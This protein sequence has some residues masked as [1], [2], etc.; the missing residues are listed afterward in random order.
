VKAIGSQ[1]G[2]CVVFAW[3]VNLVVEALSRH[4]V[5]SAVLFMWERPLVFAYNVLLIGLTFSF[6][7]LFKRKW[8]FL[9][10]MT[11][12][13][14]GLGITNS[15]LLAHRVTPFN[16]Q[17]M[18][19]LFDIITIVPRYFS[20]L[21]LAL[22]SLFIVAVLVGLVL[23]M[24][25]APVSKLPVDYG[26]S[27]ALS[28]LALGGFLFLT[29]L[30]IQ[31]NIV[32][33]TF[34]NLAMAY[35]DYGFPYAFGSSIFNTGMDEPDDYSDVAVGAIEG[36]LWDSPLEEAQFPNI[37]MVQLESF[38]DPTYLSGLTLSEDPIPNFRYL[39]DNFSSGFL[40][41]PVVGAGTVNTEF[42]V[43]TGMAIQFFGPGEIPY[44]TLLLDTA[45]ES[46]PHNLRE[47]GYSS[48]AFHN[49]TGT[50]Y[51]RHRVFSSL[52]F[53]TFT[54]SEFMNIED[55]SETGWASDQVMLDYLFAGMESTANRDFLFAI[56]VQSHGDYPSDYETVPTV[57]A[58]GWDDSERLRAFDYYLSTIQD[59]DRFIGELTKRLA[60]FPEEVVLVLYGDHLPT[61]YFQESE[62]ANRDIYQ[63]EFVVWS[64]FELPVQGRDLAA[65]ELGA[66]VLEKLGISQGIMTN[67]HQTYGGELND[68]EWFELL[69][70]DL[71][72]GEHYV[73]GGEPP[74]EP[75][76]LQMGI[77]PVSIEAVY[78]DS[79]G[80]LVVKGQNFTQASRVA[81]NGRQ[82][83]TLFV[84]PNRLKVEGLAFEAG[85][86]AT[87]R[88]VT[89][90]GKVLSET[91]GFEP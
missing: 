35:S 64:N 55:V 8:S 9:S 89:E 68:R 6:V 82:H 50:F 56:T 18:M 28:A 45:V 22:F 5:V 39:K 44:K 3:V 54:S 37:I 14:L 46:L 61:F 21:Q 66:F 72:F 29:Q 59:V 80:N 10:L 41:V 65:Y 15:L 57:Q 63:T 12:I 48:H 11:V 76:D 24:K 31:Q 67:F 88:Q 75:T 25:R 85:D 16:F 2:F 51:Q 43:L 34:G 77:L 7:I 53:D 40:R 23:L 81:V 79:A 83:H 73:Y 71:L 47:L 87:V 60:D 91:E 38:F 70:Y 84:S 13:W 1:W 20:W 30:A 19:V 52:G 26:L 62:L 86:V 78:E 49:N 90:L 4:S 69:Q 33:D 42:E 36:E 58:T 32:S 17:D 27:G 74:F